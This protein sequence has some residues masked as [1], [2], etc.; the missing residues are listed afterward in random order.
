MHMLSTNTV[1]PQP[2]SINIYNCSTFYHFK[3][4]S[5]K[6]IVF[7]ESHIISLSNRICINSIPSQCRMHSKSFALIESTNSMFISHLLADE[8]QTSTRKRLITIFV[9]ITLMH[10]ILME[11]VGENFVLFW[12]ISLKNRQMLTSLKMQNDIFIFITIN[13]ENSYENYIF[14][15]RKSILLGWNWIWTG[16]LILKTEIAYRKSLFTIFQAIYSNDSWMSNLSFLDSGT[17]TVL[18]LYVSKKVAKC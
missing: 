18:F 9:R 7:M 17:F 4:T 13:D 10:F 16:N 1:F 8:K 2:N 11:F 12:I 3:H 14:I 15:P 5:N 6:L